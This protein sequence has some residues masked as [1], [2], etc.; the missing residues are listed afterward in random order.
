MILGVF[1]PQGGSIAGLRR[2]GQDGRFVNSY[3]RTYAR[4]FEKVY[5]FSYANEEAELPPNCY[6]VRNPGYHRYAY[7][8]LLPLVQRKYIQ[9][10]DV[11]RVM[12]MYGALPAVLAKLLYGKPFV[13]TYGYR[14]LTDAHT[15]G[16]RC[17]AVLF[18]W[19]A[20][21]GL[22]LADRVIVTT[23]ELSAYVS[24]FVSPS[25]LMLLPNGVDTVLFRFSGERTARLERTVVYVGRLSL[26][27]NLALL[28]DAVALIR[29]P[30]VRLVIVGAGELR[31]QLEAHAADRGIVCEF[32]GVLP[33]EEL[34]RVLNDADV[35]VLPSSREGH[36][37]ALLEA[38]SCG[39]PCVGS[40]V[41]GI[42]D[43]LRHNETGLLCDLSERDLA[44]KIT[45][46]LVDTDLARRLGES[47]SRFAREHF[48]LIDLLGRET[49]AL[50][51]A[52]SKR[53]YGRGTD[54]DQDLP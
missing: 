22:N 11:F 6:L 39:L 20:L 52:A 23:N 28:I 15:Q 48:D 31:G 32:A 29:E 42:R 47:A 5:Y 49:E 50:T 7:A 38:M 45:Q 1:P 12:Q 27:K 30:K 4:S 43:V 36:P 8:F 16:M 51:L 40:D 46:L 14:Y 21:L 41:P 24:R 13:G 2:A 17:R 34:P 18:E 37:K 25:R 19:R 53:A 33:H 3:L 54:N 9:A 26:V 10:C 35:F 44:D